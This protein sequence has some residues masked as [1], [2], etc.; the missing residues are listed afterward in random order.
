VL[1]ANRRRRSEEK[2]L[3]KAIFAGMLLAIAGAALA[4]VDP[5]RV[6]ATV[7]GI[8]IKGA[9]Y[10]RRMEILPGVGKNLGTGFAEFPPGF[11]TLEQI[12]T[13]KLVMQLA[14]Q[15]NVAPSDKEVNDELEYRKSQSPTFIADWLSSGRTLDELM[16]DVRFDLTQFK[17]LTAGITVTDAEV[18]AF[19]KDKNNATMFTIPKQVKLRVMVAKTP[20]D[21]TVINN[22]LASGKSFA[23]VAKAHSA[24][25]TAGQGGDYGTVPFS[26]LSANVQNGI[27]NATEGKPTAWFI[28]ADGKTQFRFLVEKVIPSS[29][30]PLT[31]DVRRQIRQRLMMDRGKAKNHLRDDLNALRAKATIDIKEKGFSEAYKKFIDAY[32]KSSGG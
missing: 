8:E 5:N 13:E 1:A 28:A 27:T 19:Y 16:A 24:D 32:L 23:E 6:V 17:L 2:G 4:Q 31:A 3:K 12:I 29:V 26:A 22:E 15:K 18:D 30:V 20:E 10:Y 11:L 9:E 25:I 14:K 7:N 21:A